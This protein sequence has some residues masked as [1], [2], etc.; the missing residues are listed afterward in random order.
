MND[1]LPTDE[2]SQRLEQI[3]AYLD[4]ELSPQ[5]SA[6][7]ERRLAADEE[8]RQDL[9]S[10]ERAWG[11]LD[12]LP[13]ATVD[14]N[15]SR[16]TM[17]MVVKAAGDEVRH[18]TEAL[19]VQRRKRQFTKVLLAVGALLMGVL[20]G[21]LLLVNPNQELID[22]LPVIQYVDI[23]FQVPDADF[24]RKL[25]GVLEGEAVATSPEQSR[26][27]VSQFKLVSA[28]E[29]R[30]DWLDDLPNEQRQTLRARLN[31][32]R[33]MT[34]S[35]KQRMRDLHQEIVAEPGLQETL[36]LY[37]QW[38]QG[39]SSSEQYELR[40]LS[41][42]E[43]VR[44]I[45]GMIEAEARN[46]SLGLSDEEL[47]KLYE[48]VMTRRDAI[49]ENAMESMPPKEWREFQ[50]KS[51]Q[52]QFFQLLKRG[53][54]N[55]FVD[56]NK[57]AL[58][59]AILE[60]L[61]PEKREAYQELPRPMQLRQFM[62]WMMEA[63]SKRRQTGRRGSKK[64]PSD[65]ELEEFFVDSVDPQMYERLLAMPL[66][67]MQRLLESMYRGNLS[68]RDWTTL[69]LGERELPPFGFGRMEG[70]RGE[71]PRGPGDRGGRF[72]PPERRERPEGG[73]PRFRGEGPPE[74]DRPFGGERGFGRDRSFQG[75]PDRRPGPPPG[76]EPL[77]GE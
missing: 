76:D 4:G 35:Q 37:Q 67:K 18:M 69:E 7:V 2:R 72:G 29:N 50:K 36:L 16:T 68:S 9:Q 62:M 6:Q 13:Q 63:E 43:R 73:P 54:A 10:M 60:S 26:Q 47:Q 11:A 38:L 20:M 39:L 22:D 64:K 28:N 53:S 33:A 14:D 45:G 61:P 19:P 25:Q 1:P 49:I 77:P 52:E 5:E 27:Q 51:R 34:P 58:Y 30:E 32:F 31:R 41:P 40:E 59:S 12:D 57:L 46:R 44:R 74:R 21:K 71:G 48:G 66:D 17:E 24:L 42:E 56:F 65:Q 8:F 23:Y 70:R 55:R 75:P 3:V 15:F